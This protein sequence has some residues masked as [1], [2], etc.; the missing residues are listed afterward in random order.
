MRRQLLPSIL[1]T[2]AIALLI[3]IIFRFGAWWPFRIVHDQVF[4]P[5]GRGLHGLSIQIG[6]SVELF[7]SAST[8]SRTNAQQA[9]EII[10]LK[11]QLASLKEVA[12]END[13]LRAQLQFTDTKQYDLVAARVV[14]S[15][16]DAVRRYLSIDRGSS[17]GIKKG[18]AVLSNGIF[19]GTIDEVNDFSSRIFMVSDPEFRIRALGQDGRSQGII[20]G[21]LGSGLLYEKVAQS[22]VLGVGEFVITAGS[23]LVPKGLLIGQIQQV[24]RADNAVFQSAQVHGLVDPGRAELV[25]VIRGLQ[26]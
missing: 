6:D 3:L 20:R 10:D 18:M 7:K 12:K 21:Q 22:E 19:V 11:K 26:Q 25:F 13:Q 2:S 17:S 1:V 14:G 16:P 23:E 15:D 9:I 8:L 24:N 4:N 5:I